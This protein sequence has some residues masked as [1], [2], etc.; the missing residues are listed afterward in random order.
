MILLKKK[1]SFKKDFAYFVNQK[2]WERHKNSR[3]VIR[4]IELSK[5]W[6]STQE[7]ASNQWL[8]IDRYD[9]TFLF[10]C[11]YW[12]FCTYRENWQLCVNSWMFLN[13][14]IKF[15][16]NITHYHSDFFP[17]KLAH[18]FLMDQVL[19]TLNLNKVTEYIAIFIA[20]KYQVPQ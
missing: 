11:I 6:P 17:I 5:Y 12:L 3:Q 1:V 19:S 15:Q 4:K 18:W 16:Y 13:I 2:N 8:V 10:W 9:N 20:L 7:N 14:A